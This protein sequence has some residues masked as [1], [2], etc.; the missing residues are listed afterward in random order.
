MLI[1]TDELQA[2]LDR[3]DVV[4][5]DARSKMDHFLG[6]V[7]GAVQTGWRDFSDPGSDIKGLLDPDFCRLEATIG[8]LGISNDRDVIV[9][10]DAPEYWG[11]D[12]RIY[13]MLS[14]LGHRK[15]RIVD[16]GWPKWKNERRVIERGPVRPRPAVFCATPSDGLLIE[17]GEMAEAVLDGNTPFR[18]IDARSP[19]EYDGSQPEKDVPRGGHIPTAVNV[20]F[21]SFFRPDGSLMAPEEIRAAYEGKGICPEDDVVVYCTGGVRSS[22]LFVTL[23]RAG[24]H[25][26]RNYVGSWWEWSR[27]PDLPVER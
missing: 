11:A 20:P 16:G 6:H 26:V 22:W 8:A 5:V 18:L 13:W 24:Y 27:D 21:D 4:I 12:G 25:R 23:K 3:N 15:V 14:Y 7:P 1:R 17:K 2:I 9:Y 19:G 10:S